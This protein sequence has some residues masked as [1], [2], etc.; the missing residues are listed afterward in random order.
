M[1]GIEK[2]H[3]NAA[4]EALLTAY[5]ATMDST[6]EEMLSP[7]LAYGK[8][9]TL[10]MDAMPEIIITTELLKYD[11]HGVVITEETGIARGAQSQT[12]N[13][14]MFRTVFISDPTDRSAQ[15]AKFLTEIADKS[16]KVGV[17]MRGLETISTWESKFGA[18]ASI[19]G[20]SSAISCLRRGVPIFTVIINYVTHQFFLSC[21]AGSYCVDLSVEFED[22]DVDKICR[23]G[24]QLFFRQIGKRDGS[25]KRFV[26]FTGKVGYSENLEH[27][28]LMS[29]TEIK[30]YLHYSL[31]GGPLRILYLSDLQPAENPIGFILA[32]GEKI[33]EWIHWLSFV[34]FARNKVDI[35]EPALSLH[36]VYQDRP[37]TKEGIL[38]STPPAYSIF[39]KQ[40][41]TD[42]RVTINVGR[43]SDFDNPCR[44]R[45]TLLV[46][47][48]DNQWA[49]RVVNQYGYR[50]LVLFG[51]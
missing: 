42:G 48:S 26:T 14:Q 25:V 18:P 50:K 43:F 38:M 23:G 2:A 20:G 5:Y 10:G 8:K 46:A 41:E 9:D 44:I 4:I 15:L 39:Q 11:Q 31:P 6:V 24:R 40:G 19:T 49:T 51:E 36:E 30:Q 29:P 27:S 13:A 37:W 12:D 7:V 33:S 22:L 3:C 45:A 32:N 34:R 47:P 28:N 1:N 35:M 16:I 17:A 21:S